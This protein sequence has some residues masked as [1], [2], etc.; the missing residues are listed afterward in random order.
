MGASLAAAQPSPAA[1]NDGGAFT[2]QG[3]TPAPASQPAAAQS[4][5]RVSIEPDGAQG[6]VYR[7]VD[8]LTG[9]VLVELPREKVEQLTASPG[10]AAGALVSTSA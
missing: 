5:T 1:A 6:Y 2:A 10:Y 4:A 7:L 3:Q 8:R 9:R